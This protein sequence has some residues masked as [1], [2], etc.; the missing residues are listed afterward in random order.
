MEGRRW[1]DGSRYHKCA[2][3]AHFPRLVSTVKVKSL[4]E[5]P[6]LDPSPV[7]PLPRDGPIP[8]WITQSPRDWGVVDIARA[9]EQFCRLH[10]LKPR[11]HS[12]KP[13]TG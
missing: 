1:G 11:L 2:M 13:Y 9:P 7:A 8:G 3:L 6:L 12:V 10:R 4:P 5:T